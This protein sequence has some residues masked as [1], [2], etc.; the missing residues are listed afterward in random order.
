MNT[1]K[2]YQP[3]LFESVMI[4]KMNHVASESAM[5]T[6]L[7]DTLDMYGVT[8]STM[9]RFATPEEIAFVESVREYTLIN[10][11]KSLKLESCFSNLSQ[12]RELAM[13]YAQK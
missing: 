7:Y 13:E 1:K 6:Y 3:S 4:N 10:I 12:I 5:S 2:F 9:D 8:E 11:A